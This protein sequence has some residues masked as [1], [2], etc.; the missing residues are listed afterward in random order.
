MLNSPFNNIDGSTEHRRTQDREV[1]FNNGFGGFERDG[2]AY[3]ITLEKGMVTPAPWSNVI[4]N[5]EFGFIVTE[6]GGG[7]TWSD[8]SRENRLSPWSN[9][10]VSDGLGEIIYLSDGGSD[11]W[12][13]TPLPIR[14]D[15]TY[16][17]KHGFGFTE[18][19]H[20]SHGITQKLTQFVPVKGKVKISRLTLTNNRSEEVQLFATYYLRPVLGVSCQDT[21]TFLETSQDKDG[22]L[23]V[24]NRYNQDFGKQVC[25]L[26]S[27]I[28]NRTVTGDRKNFFGS[29]TIEAPAALLGEKIVSGIGVGY[30]PCAVMQVKVV[31]KAMETQEVDFVLG[32][33]DDKESA[34]EICSQYRKTEYVNQEKEKVD[35]FWSSKLQVLQVKTQDPAM[36]LLLNGW[37]MYQV[38]SCRLWS[39]SG[40]YQSGGAFG[41]RDQLQDSLS[42]ATC[43]PEITRAQILKHA[44]HQFTE[45]DVLH[46]WHEPSG[47]GTRTRISDDFLWL[48]YVT[49]EYLA[50]TDDQSILKETA[51][52][53][54]DPP[55]KEGEEERY[56]TPHI[57][58]HQESIYEHCIRAITH[59]LRF[60][61]RGLPLMGGGDWNDGMNRVGI[62][63]KGESIWLGW[64]LASIL[65]KFIPICNDWGD[66]EKA[67]QY[68]EIRQTI[69][70][71]IEREGWDGNWY[72]R[73][74]FDDG[75]PLGSANNTECKIDSLAQT[76]AVISG[77]GNPERA[78][79]AMASLEDYLVMREEGLIK[80]LTP[81]FADGV[82]EPGYIKGY[83]PGVRENG[84]QYSHAAAWV[85]MAFALLKEG[86][87]AVELFGLINPI[88]HTRTPREVSIYKVEP[89]VMAADVYSEQPHVGRGGWTWYTGSAGW[90]YT[91]GIEN[92]LGFK[93]R[94]QLLTID[95]CVPNKWQSYTMTYQFLETRYQIL[96]RNSSSVY[97]GV[98]QMLMD[99]A[100]ISDN[101]I[102]LIND[103]FS[104]QVDIIIGTG[105]E[106]M[107][108]EVK[109]IINGTGAQISEG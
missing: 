63:G 59:G 100:I 17:I 18:F 92:I 46:W 23:Y 3:I 108:A 93:K 86:D 91:A 34:L 102:H 96:V 10:P 53:L 77:A 54:S 61:E 79:K 101:V 71:A 25:F 73:A 56:L 74:Y 60:G 109:D 13:V 72:R 76:W 36:D 1:L 31:I 43:W 104:H 33:A 20:V 58:I 62:E 27:S 105:A 65:Q 42:L 52:Y 11:I 70:G 24:E 28:E 39:R 107:M 26:D 69:L 22:I 44:A 83:V 15:E 19:I 16:T 90:M 49:A 88:N 37:L 8:N 97:T 75:T 95:P 12:T 87:K 85:V 29:G 68:E 51:T 5:P 64:F 38:I 82:Q 35:L 4:A 48:P 21:D 103:G 84:G 2:A 41:F 9:D 66:F 99:G 47:K 30:D 78:N 55:L 98:R 106:M 40:F 45:G 80:L 50:I 89:Y 6:S 57:S 94:G 67:A 81:P 14:E 7:F 32:T